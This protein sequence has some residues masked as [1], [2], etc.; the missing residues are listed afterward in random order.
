MRYLYILM[1]VMLIPTLSHA[2]F[3]KYRDASGALRFTD[4]LAE[5]PKDQRPKVQ[6][7]KEPDDYLTPEQKAAKLKAAREST[8]TASPGQKTTSLEKTQATRMDLNKKKMALDQEYGELMKTKEA[9]MAGENEAMK[10]QEGTRAHREKVTRL[11]LR[12]V[13]FEKRRK[14]FEKEVDAFEKQRSE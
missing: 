8:D 14:A 9:L 6:K 13:D 5:V 11:N 7:Y 12:I 2:E 10:T 1:I 3:Y 4:N